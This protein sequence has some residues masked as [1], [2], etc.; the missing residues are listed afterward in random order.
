MKPQQRSTGWAKYQPKK[1]KLISW[2]L[3]RWLILILSAELAILIILVALAKPFPAYATTNVMATRKEE[4]KTISI[5]AWVTKYAW[6]GYTMANNEY[7]YVGAV[8]T[9]DRSIPFGTRV[10]I[11]GK[12]YV[13]KDRTALWVFNER[14]QVFDIY[15]EETKQDMLNFGKQKLE[16]LIIKE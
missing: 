12:E 15:S 2:E 3:H 8:A 5:S 14:G 7:P 10:I 4:I 16:V 6:T 13:V 11:N 9:S 1:P